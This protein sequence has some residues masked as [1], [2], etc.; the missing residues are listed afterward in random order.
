M[1]AD[2]VGMRPG[3]AVVIGDV[4]KRGQLLFTDKKTPG[5]RYTAPGAGTVVAVNR[6]ERRALQSVVIEL[7]ENEL[8]GQVAGDDQV[9]FEGYTGKEPAGLSRDEIKALLVESGMWTVLRTRP[10][11][12]VPNPETEPAA[13]F[14]S[15]M[16]TNPLAP[17]V[18]TILNGNKGDFE[19]GLL[20]V[21]KLTEGKTYVCK[22]PGANV[23]VNP[24]TGIQVE[25]FEGPH[26]AGTV[27][28]HIHRL[29]PVHRE[30]TVWHLNY[31]E[32][33]AIGRLF[34][35]GQLDFDRIVALSG[36][37]VKKPRLLKTRVGASVDDLVM[38][39]LEEG[40]NRV[41]SGS[42]LSG[43]AAMG[44]VLGYLGRHHHQISAVREG[45]D[46]EFL[47]WMAPGAN[48]FS[49][50]RV[51]MSALSKGKKF[52]LTTNTNG[53]ERAMV[54]IGSYERVMPMDI[55][56]TFLLRA[57]AVNDIERAEQ[58]GC[59]ELD[60]EDLALCTFVCP[61]KYDYGPILRRNLDIIEK[62]G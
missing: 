18:E 26:P 21:A 35:T 34:G 31:Q 23:P 36:P 53:G 52:A 37:V 15:A 33:V 51:F 5:V 60:E 43:R 7:N 56:P 28:L 16:D 6:G 41:I 2:Y 42:V 50:V 22:A 44:E 47:G 30:K 4:V 39:E 14:V 58:L 59:L 54:P 25:E 10:F 3:M 13:L 20:C 11:S 8:N 40:E 9:A 38:D 27:G 57:L 17:S 19:R 12:K 32:V 55:M 61:S 45:R 1:A 46:R 49:I 24:N 29:E 48:K 62:E